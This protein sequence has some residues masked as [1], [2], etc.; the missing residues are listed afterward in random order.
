MSAID[1]VGRGAGRLA[2]VACV[3]MV[4]LGA[5]NAIARDVERHV[6]VGLSSNAFLEGQW[7]LFSV[8]FLLGAA[9][10]LAAGRHVRVDVLWS[11]LSPRARARID[12]AGTILFLVPFCSLVLVTSWPMVANSFAVREGSP[13]PG[14]LPRYPVK[15]LIPIAFT[16]LLVQGVAEGVRAFRASR[17]RG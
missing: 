13:D 17:E 15:A 1:R 3:A 6:G 5:Y 16:L 2:S 8:V 10:T 9:R 7:V 4:F 14:G 11:R 12:L